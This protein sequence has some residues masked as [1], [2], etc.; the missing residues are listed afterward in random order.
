[1]SKTE[2]L[3]KKQTNKT[4]IASVIVNG[5]KKKNYYRPADRQVECQFLTFI[6]VNTEQ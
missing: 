1:M 5:I 2:Y 6:S 3:V 4:F